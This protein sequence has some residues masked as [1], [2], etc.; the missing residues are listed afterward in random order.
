MFWDACGESEFIYLWTQD[1]LFCN[2][3]HTYNAEGINVFE[4]CSTIVYQA[5]FF[6]IHRNLHYDK[7]FVNCDTQ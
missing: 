6:S 5:S 2:K 3:Y 1:G 7:I 4:S